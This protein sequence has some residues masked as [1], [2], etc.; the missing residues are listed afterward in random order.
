MVTGQVFGRTSHDSYAIYD[1]ATSSLRTHRTLR[2]R[3]STESYV[4]LPKAGTMQ[5]GTVYERT[6]SVRHTCGNDCILLPTPIRS[7]KNDRGARTDYSRRLNGPSGSPRLAAIIGGP[8]NPNHR[9]WLMGFPIGWTK[10]SNT[11][12]RL[13]ATRSFRKSLNT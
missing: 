3:V 6:T 11:E 7:D 12:L 5:N 4:T 8:S 1:P 2:R 10:I 9:E 13:L